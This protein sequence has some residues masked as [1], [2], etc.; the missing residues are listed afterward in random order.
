MEFVVEDIVRLGFG[1]ANPNHAAA[2]ICALF[3]F[4]WGW[5]G[6]LGDRALPA[7][8]VLQWCGRVAG[9]ALCVMLA[10]TY[11]RTGMAVLAIE[12]AVLLWCKMAASKVGG[13]GVRHGYHSKLPQW[14]KFMRYCSA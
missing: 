4:C 12:V 10:M 3:P 2:A 1:F 6:A 5:G 7:R 11:S 13:Y 14:R 8:G 9:V